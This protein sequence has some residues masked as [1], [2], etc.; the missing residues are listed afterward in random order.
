VGSRA[1]LEVAAETKK[2]RALQGIEKN[3]SS[4]VESGDGQVNFFFTL[5][6]HV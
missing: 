2:S 5:Y 4:F 1:C 3:K 6:V